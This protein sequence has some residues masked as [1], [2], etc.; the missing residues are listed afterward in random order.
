[1]KLKT[2]RKF[3]FLVSESAANVVDAMD[4][5]VDDFVEQHRRVTTSASEAREKDHEP[6]PA[7]S[8]HEDSVEPPVLREWPDNSADRSG[9]EPGSRSARLIEA[10]PQPHR[11]AFT[12]GISADTADRIMQ[13]SRERKNARKVKS[14][15]WLMLVL[16]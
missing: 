15:S 1:M 13:Q 12:R 10:L 9:P 5:D 8:Q 16:L 2:Q 7:T 3:V 14:S 4:V 11:R 6:H